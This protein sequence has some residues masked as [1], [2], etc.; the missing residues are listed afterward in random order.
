MT[1]VSI[2]RPSGGMVRSVTNSKYGI[3]EKQDMIMKLL[4]PQ[5]KVPEGDGTCMAVK[6]CRIRSV[7]RKFV[8]NKLRQIW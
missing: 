1:V 4:Q 8:A 3:P 6:S 5:K 7:N 2:H